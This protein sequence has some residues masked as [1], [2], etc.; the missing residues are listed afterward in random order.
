MSSSA[1]QKALSYKIKLLNSQLKAA[2][3][4]KI[5]SNKLMI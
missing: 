4:S 2:F 5:S 1:Q 3:K